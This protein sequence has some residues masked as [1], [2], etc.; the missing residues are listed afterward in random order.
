MAPA[1]RPTLC[2]DCG[3]HYSRRAAVCPRCRITKLCPSCGETKHLNQFH[4]AKNRPDGVQGNC[5]ACR[6]FDRVLKMY[7]LTRDE[8]EA[9]LFAQN[10][11][12][13]ICLSPP[14]RRGWAVD[15]DHSCCPGPR[16]C[17]KC[18]RGL[19]CDKCN[20][21]LGYFNELPALLKR[22]AN[23]LEEVSVLSSK[24]AV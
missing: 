11:V 4:K 16:S 5:I 22:A 24:L 14:G 2:R 17:G 15:H 9:L 19:L 18:V 21:G 23:Y 3:G 1:G 20:I 10:G 13:A 7:N 8:Y 6:S 12:C